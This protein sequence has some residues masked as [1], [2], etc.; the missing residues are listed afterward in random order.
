M[1]FYLVRRVLLPRKL[2]FLVKIGKSVEKAEDF[3]FG[4]YIWE[5]AKVHAKTLETLE[6]HLEPTIG[7]VLIERQH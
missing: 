5:D 4:E 6:I 1:G 7:V 3:R 2:C